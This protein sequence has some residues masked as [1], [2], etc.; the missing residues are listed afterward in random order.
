MVWTPGLN[1]MVE[2]SDQAVKGHTLD[3]L[4]YYKTPAG[5]ITRL[6]FEFADGRIAPPKGTYNFSP[7]SRLMYPKDRVASI[8]FHVIKGILYLLCMKSESETLE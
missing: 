1:E 3:K 5:Q 6:T 8:E 7:N 4:L 2:W